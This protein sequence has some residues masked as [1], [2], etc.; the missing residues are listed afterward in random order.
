MDDR[1]DSVV[2]DETR[3]SFDTLCSIW[4]CVNGFRFFRHFLPLS[5]DRMR[6]AISPNA[7][8]SDVRFAG[9]FD[10]LC[11]SSCGFSERGDV[12]RSGTRG[13]FNSET[14]LCIPDFAEYIGFEDST[15]FGPTSAAPLGLTTWTSWSHVALGPRVLFTGRL[16]QLL[17][18]HATGLGISLLVDVRLGC[19]DH[20]LL[21]W[22]QVEAL[23]KH[24][25]FFIRLTSDSFALSST[26]TTLVH[27]DSVAS[28]LIL[29]RSPRKQVRETVIFRDEEVV[30][31]TL[32]KKCVWVTVVGFMLPHSLLCKKGHLAST[33]T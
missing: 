1:D 29:R 20:R 21:R 15:L 30:F 22:W 3:P 19:E 12:D 25:E 18:L 33:G 9:F 32:A 14:E 26:I 23:A 24:I 27:E 28:F 17:R 13:A 7:V 16:V 8:W 31:L 10:I 2:D 4:D 5:C 6:G 11:L